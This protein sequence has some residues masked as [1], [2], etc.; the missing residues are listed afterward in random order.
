MARRSIEPRID[1]STTGEAISTKYGLELMRERD[2]RRWVVSGSANA[3]Q[4]Q[5]TT[6]GTRK[7]RMEMVSHHPLFTCA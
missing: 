2:V 3:Q 1:D 6:G 7:R 4:T 5:V